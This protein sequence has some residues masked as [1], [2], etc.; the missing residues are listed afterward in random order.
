MARFSIGTLVLALSFLN[1]SMPVAAQNA[2]PGGLT[3]KGL[4]SVI[5]AALIATDGEDYFE[6]NLK[7]ATVPGGAGGVTLFTGTLLSAEPPAHPSVLVIAISDNS[8]PEVTL[9]LKDSDWKD[10]HLSG[11][12][13]RSSVIQFEGVPISFTKKP[14]MLTFGVSTTQRIHVVTGRRH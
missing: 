3:S 2:K 6:N 10:S 1:G 14:F 7:G 11:P 4:W 9:Q 8:T 13:A 5:K 12:I